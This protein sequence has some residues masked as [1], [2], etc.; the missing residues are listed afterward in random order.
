MNR[1]RPWRRRW[2]APALLLGL[3]VPLAVPARYYWQATRPLL[4]KDAV[5][6]YAAQHGLD[7]LF[8]LA[9]VRVES[10][11]APAARSHR[12]AIGL[13]QLMPDTAREMARRI[14]EDPA[15]LNLEEPETNIRLGVYY[16]ALLTREF[17]DDEVALLAAYNAGPANARAWRKDGGR[18]L[19]SDITFP[20]TRVFVER[21]R[22]TH[23]GF[24]ALRRVK[25]F[26]HV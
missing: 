23:R 6:R 2:L 21:V 11:F 4:H 14:G 7:P 26:F 13:M 15:R 1:L 5:D 18:L 20:E 22:R 24:H 9:L 12:G 8:V 25:R 17:G 16:L 3:L 10:G 19:P